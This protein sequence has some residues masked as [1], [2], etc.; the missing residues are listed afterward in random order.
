MTN[1]QNYSQE[2]DLQ[3]I[4]LIQ[5]QI[6]YVYNIDKYSILWECKTIL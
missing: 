4:I 6:D 2:I 1:D 5:N 3:A